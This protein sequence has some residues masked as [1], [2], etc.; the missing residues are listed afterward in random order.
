MCKTI[1]QGVQKSI[2]T[3]LC[4]LLRPLWNPLLKQ[5]NTGKQ[6][7]MRKKYEWPRL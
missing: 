1:P 2:R 5:R 6:L 3:V 4:A 7:K